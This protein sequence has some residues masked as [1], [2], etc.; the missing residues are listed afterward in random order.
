[1]ENSVQFPIVNSLLDLDLE[2][3]K[4]LFLGAVDRIYK[5]ID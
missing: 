5:E 2:K 1:M 3:L 4:R